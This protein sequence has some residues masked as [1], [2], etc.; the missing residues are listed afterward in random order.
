MENQRRPFTLLLLTSAVNRH[1]LLYTFTSYAARQRETFQ[2]SRL[3]L[4]KCPGNLFLPRAPWCQQLGSS[5]RFYLPFPHIP[6]SPETRCFALLIYSI[7]LGKH[8]LSSR[9]N[10]EANRKAELNQQRPNWSR[11]DCVP[12]KNAKSLEKEL[13][14]LLRKVMGWQGRFPLRLFCPP[15]PVFLISRILY[16]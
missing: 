9:S 3:T 5:S 12:K 7:F 4:F 1:K 2:G 10:G 11:M 14:L 15:T 8:A 16:S 13:S 6:F